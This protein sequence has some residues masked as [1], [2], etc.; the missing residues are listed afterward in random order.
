M[1]LIVD[2]PLLD[3][4]SQDL[5][6]IGDVVSEANAFA[7]AAITMVL[8]AGA[9]EVS[10][11][12]SNLF[13]VH[14]QIYQQLAAQAEWFHQQ[15]TTTLGACA[16]A[17]QDIEVAAQ[18]T[19][20]FTGGEALPATTMP[21][22]V[23]PVSLVVGGTSWPVMPPSLL[24]NVT[25]AYHLIN[26]YALYTPE[27]LFPLTPQIGGM[28]LDQSVAAGSRDL[29]DAIGTQLAAGNQVTV[30]GVSQ[31][32]I[33]ETGAIRALIAQGSPGLGKLNFILAGDLNNPDGGLLE[34]FVG[35][36]VP[37]LGI[38]GT[39]ATPPTSPYPTA[40]YT[41]QYDPASNFP[42]YPLNLISD[43]NAVAGIPTHQHFYEPATLSGY[44]QLPTS[45]GY[46]GDTAYY[47]KLDQ[48]LPLT[49]LLRT[50][51]PAP[52][53]NAFAD[54][55][56]PD[57]RVLVDMGYG[58]NEYANIPTPGSLLEIPN[59]W[60]VLPDLAHGT[61]QGLNAFGVD[62]GWLPQS[63]YPTGYPSAPILNPDLNFDLPQ[64]PSTGL[65]VLLAGEGALMRD[66]GYPV[67]PIQFNG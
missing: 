33:V 60:T 55:L 62:M 17:D 11:A 29:V 32:A 24:R 54:L 20:Q 61:A 56:Q 2:P 18:S 3:A 5:G 15:F 4:A 65:S 42:R 22:N 21:T 6:A 45:P 58:S 35:G 43:L 47:F 67:A 10:A 28:T 36:Y 44:T 23:N 7:R 31:G 50:Y 41:N 14:G 19:L 57:M 38:T 51:V 46:T 48:T 12:I 37:G 1:N 9:D 63:D 30:W 26:P 40:I 16:A 27:Q 49:N 13:N 8:P 59:P 66:L 25:S 53:G 39:G 64:S 34:R 52:Y